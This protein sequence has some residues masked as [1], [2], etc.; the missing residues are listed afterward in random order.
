MKAAKAGSRFFQNRN[1]EHFPCHTGVPEEEFNCLFCYCPLYA[2]GERCG[3]AFRY[4]S[5]GVK[6][7]SACGFP[8]LR[9]NYEKVIGRFP[10]IAALAAKRAEP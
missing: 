9:R 1:C 5:S 10:E 7:C 4:L 3:G 8:H 2:L 6:D